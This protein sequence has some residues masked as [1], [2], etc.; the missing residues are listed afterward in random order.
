[1]LL[2]C[3]LTGDI[4]NHCDAVPN[5]L[6]LNHDLELCNGDN[7]DLNDDMVDLDLHDGITNGVSDSED[8]PWIM[9]GLFYIR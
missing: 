5:D 3:C 7:L 4:P 1:M 6:N 2:T 9:N 8:A